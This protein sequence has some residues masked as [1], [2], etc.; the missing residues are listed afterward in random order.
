MFLV[1][2]LCTVAASQTK[3]RRRSQPEAPA[4]PSA[5]QLV[6]MKKVTDSFAGLWKTTTTVEPGAFLPKGGS[7]SGHADIRSGPAGNSLI[8]R[9]R[10]RGAL[11]NFAGMGTI[12]WDA[13]AAAY[14]GLWCDSLSPTGCDMT[15]TGQ[16]DGNNLVFTGDSEMEGKKMQMRET[17]SDIT[18]DS[19]TFTMDMGID[20]AP[21]QKAMTIKYERAVPRAAAASPAPEGQN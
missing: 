3:H 12:W 17:Y 9:T 6:E 21:L 19:F 13:K 2:G 4:I 20:G 1:V 5:K 14:R 11:G 10:S 16:W 18:I 15:G 8:E 7:A